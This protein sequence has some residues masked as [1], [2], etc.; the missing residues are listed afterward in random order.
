MCFTDV[1]GEFLRVGITSLGLHTWQSV[2]GAS[3]AHAEQNPLLAAAEVSRILSS[4]EAEGISPDRMIYEAAIS[5]YVRCGDGDQAIKLYERM[6]KANLATKLEGGKDPIE[7]M[8]LDVMDAAL[9]G[10]LAS[11]LGTSEEQG[12]L[13]GTSKAGSEQAPLTQTASI[14]QDLAEAGIRVKPGAVTSIIRRLCVDVSPQ[15]HKSEVKVLLAIRKPMVGSQPPKE[16]EASAAQDRRVQRLERAMGLVEASDH[17]FGMQATSFVYGALMEACIR[18]QQVEQV[19]FLWQQ[20]RSGGVTP[21]VGTWVLRIQALTTVGS[22]G[23]RTHNL[24]AEAANDQLELHPH[25]LRA[26]LKG[27]YH[28]KDMASV[29]HLQRMLDTSARVQPSL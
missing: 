4:M 21:D 1:A 7:R 23:V 6:Q 26:L 11:G 29:A 3:V 5:I 17:L 25:L 19:E 2:I 14:V 18:L 10:A 15:D 13:L 8:L 22:I 9:V 27:C 16:I 24:L 12:G 28:V 20:M